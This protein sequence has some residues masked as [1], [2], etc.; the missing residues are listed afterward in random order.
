[1]SWTAVTALATS[2]KVTVPFSRFVAESSPMAAVPVAVEIA[3]KQERTIS[4]EAGG[5]EQELRQLHEFGIIYHPHRP[6]ILGVMAR[7][8][9]TDRLAKVLR[10][11]TRL[12]YEEVDKQS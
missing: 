3:T 4:P 7:G 2:E 6:F 8:T 12:V 1:M 5:E 11:I 9:D 10:D